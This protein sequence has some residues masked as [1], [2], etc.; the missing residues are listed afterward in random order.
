MIEATLAKKER[1]EAEAERMKQD[2][3]RIEARN[4]RQASKAQRI[5]DQYGNSS[6]HRLH[7][8]LTFASS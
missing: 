1:G 2:L 7:A 4:E 6:F 8:Q 5:T 3:E